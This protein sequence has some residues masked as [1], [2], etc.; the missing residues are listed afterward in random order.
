[1]KD[2]ER[3]LQIYKKYKKE[4]GVV[5][6]K[7]EQQQLFSP[8]YPIP[9]AETFMSMTMFRVRENAAATMIQ[10]MFRGYKCR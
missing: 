6:T 8:L 7:A 2:L 1:M 5:L 9:Q 3:K 10:S 4:Q